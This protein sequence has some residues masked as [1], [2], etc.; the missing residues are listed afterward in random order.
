MIELILLI[1]FVGVMLIVAMHSENR[2]NKEYQNGCY[3]DDCVNE[4]HRFILE[5]QAEVE[6][7]PIVPTVIQ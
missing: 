1:L 5:K 6:R 2:H 3:E 7:V 4:Y